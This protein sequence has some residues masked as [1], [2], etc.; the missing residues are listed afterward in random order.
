[1]IKGEKIYV[2]S[3]PRKSVQGRDQYSYK[4]DDGTS[5]PAGR[6]KAK[7]VSIPVGFIQRG[8]TLITG[9]DEMVINPFYG[10]ELNEVPQDLKIGANWYS[11]FGMISGQKSISR[12][13]L[14]EIYDDVAEGTYTSQVNIPS[15]AEI[16][17]DAKRLAAVEYT[18]LASF[19]I[20][21]NEGINVFD[22]ST[23]RGRLAI[24]VCKNHPK[25]AKDKNQINESV[26]EFYIAE[27]EESVRE[28][29]RKM[30]MVMEGLQKLGDLF[31]KYDMFTRY[32]VAI[33][34]DVVGGDVSDSL[35]EMNLKT[36]IWD[37]KSNRQGTQLERISKFLE[38]YDLLVKD[39]DRVYIKY[40]IRSAVNSGVMNLVSGQYIWKSQKGIENLYKLGTSAIKVENM[41]FAE[42]EA[43]DPDVNSED[44]AFNRLHTELK[45]KGIRCK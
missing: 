31:S 24:Q 22:S 14:Y 39:K 32:Q 34:L 16:M 17:N 44:N 5:I 2:A 35:V 42:M 11:K 36:F 6:T 33:I 43:F 21:L 45:N 13:T 23:S 19:R 1:M 29:N 41:F 26:H 20:Y 18:E 10:M 9:L 37:Q 28:T 25:I 3:V 4:N 27:E 15:M 8:N 7:G 38:L 40:L 12:Q 30:D